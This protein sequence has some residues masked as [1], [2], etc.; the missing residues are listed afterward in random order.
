MAIPSYQM[1]TWAPAN[2]ILPVDVSSVDVTLPADLYGWKLHV[3]GT[4][5]VIYVDAALPSA[6]APGVNVPLYV[7]QGAVAPVLVKK[8]YHTSTTATGIVAIK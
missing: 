3:T 1:P 4:G 5:G 7:A 2:E 8:V 6:D